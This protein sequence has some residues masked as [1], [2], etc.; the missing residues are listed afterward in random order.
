MVVEPEKLD[1]NDDRVI[2]RMNVE[3]MPRGI[4]WNFVRRRREQPAAWPVSQPGQLTRSE[5]RR[6]TGY[7]ALAGLLVV[8]IYAVILVLFILFC[9]HIWFR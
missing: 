1:D 2:C 6:Y 5:A 4:A 8:I 3:G 7:S 9:T